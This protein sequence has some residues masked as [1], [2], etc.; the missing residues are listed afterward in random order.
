MRIG[1]WLAIHGLAQCLLITSSLAG[2]F[3]DGLAAWKAGDYPVA[4]KLLM[5]LA[6][7]D[8]MVAEYHLAVM[9]ARGLGVPRDDAEAVNWYRRA[10]GRGYAPAQLALG[11][12]HDQGRGVPQSLSMAM[13]WYRLAAQQ[14]DVT[15]QVTLGLIYGSGRG[16]PQNHW[17]ALKWFGLAA[18]QGNATAQ[19]NLGLLYARGEGVAEDDLQAYVWFSLAAAAGDAAAAKNRD[20]LSIGMTA[21]QMG[22]AQKR[23][24]QW[25]AARALDKAI[26]CQA[27]NSA[28]CAGAP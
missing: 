1:S 25:S 26:K 9:Y 24:E 18:E 10:A 20:A 16:V 4:L 28:D 3:E 7:Q 14:G 22:Q 27:S 19:N 21:K 6:K 11:I 2:E 13:K 8:H 17:Q 5:P 12:S 15:A 23:V